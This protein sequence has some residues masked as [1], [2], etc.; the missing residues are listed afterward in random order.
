MDA[1][2][3]GRKSSLVPMMR[4]TLRINLEDSI[5]KAVLCEKNTN[6]VTGAQ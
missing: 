2:A 3:S 4:L 1:L 6:T 5:L